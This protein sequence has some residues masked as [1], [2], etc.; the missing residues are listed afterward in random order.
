M[1]MHFESQLISSL[2]LHNG[3]PRR[4][5]DF[6]IRKFMNK[7]HLTQSSFNSFY[8]QSISQL[9]KLSRIFFNL[10][11]TGEPSIHLE[12]EL[13]DFF[14]KKLQDEVQLT[15]IHVTNKLGQLFYHKEKQPLLFCSNV[16]Y[17]LKCSCGSSYIGQTRRNIKF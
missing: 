7:K 4:F 9:H 12:K 10:P 17:R 11:Y 3:Y 2:L 16:V 15:I 5:I 6:Q 1:F 14:R 8:S 13:I